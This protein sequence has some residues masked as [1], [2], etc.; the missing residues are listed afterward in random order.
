MKQVLRGIYRF[1]KGTRNP[2]HPGLVLVKPQDHIELVKDHEGAIFVLDDL[3]ALPLTTRLVREFAPECRAYATEVKETQSG[4]HLP[5]TNWGKLARFVTQVQNGFH[6]KV[7]IAG[8]FQDNGLFRGYSGPAADVYRELGKC[9]I[10][11][12]IL[13]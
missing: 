9:A 6:K 11:R 13:K 7:Q 10:K 3:D 8:N 2:E 12:K 4:L 5:Y 1:N